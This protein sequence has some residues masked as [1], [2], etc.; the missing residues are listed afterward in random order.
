MLGARVWSFSIDSDKKP[1][2]HSFIA[3][4]T[5]E[6]NT[7][8][9][10][11]DELLLTD[12]KTK[13]WDEETEKWLYIIMN[14][15]KPDLGFYA[16]TDLGSLESE[17]TDFDDYEIVGSVLGLVNG[18]G[19][20]HRHSLGFRS[21]YQK[22]IALCNNDASC[23]FIYCDNPGNFYITRYDE[24]PDFQMIYRYCVDCFDK[25]RAG[26]KDHLLSISGGKLM[27]Y[28]RNLFYKDLAE[29]YDVE[30]IPYNKLKEVMG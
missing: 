18:Y 29:K 25:N 4:Y 20:I 17:I 21:E 2:L 28:H 27:Q 5:W 15:H 22:I 13:F 7:V 6:S 30:L 3:D 9:Q 10:P 23:Q 11:V 1:K 26:V 19:K 14:A 24:K 16:M 12:G 8:G